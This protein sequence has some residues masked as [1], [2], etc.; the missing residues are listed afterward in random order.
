MRGQFTWAYKQ[1]SEQQFYKWGGFSSGLSL[2]KVVSDHGWSLI[3][4][5]S[6][7]GWFLIRVVCHQGG[8]MGGLSGWSLI[9]GGLS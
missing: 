9:M 6:H 7:H 4:V 2:I 8:I 1:A 3:R 5:V